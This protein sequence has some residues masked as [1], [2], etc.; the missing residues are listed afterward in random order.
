MLTKRDPF[1]DAIMIVADRVAVFVC[2]TAVGSLLMWGVVCRIA[3]RTSDGV[4]FQLAI[5]VLTGR[6]GR[7]AETLFALTFILAAFGTSLL[8]FAL[9]AL[10]RR[11]ARVSAG[12]LRGPQQGV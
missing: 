6:T 11:R 8:S 1:L 9:F 3:L 12:H 2:L 7:V 5:E 10:W 4:A